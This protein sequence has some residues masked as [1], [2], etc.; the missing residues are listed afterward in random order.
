MHICSLLE[1]NISIGTLYY[2]F[3]HVCICT[4]AYWYY[5]HTATAIARSHVIP[6]CYSLF[7]TTLTQPVGVIDFRH[8]VMKKFQADSKAWQDTSSTVP[9]DL[10]QKNL[11]W[12]YRVCAEGDGKV[13]VLN[14]RYMVLHCLD[15]AS[16][17]WAET[18]QVDTSYIYRA[19]GAAGTYSNRRLYVSGGTTPAGK[20]HSTMVSLAV[21]QG[22]NS[23]VA[24]QQQPD[25]LYRRSSHGMAGV[26]GRILVCGGGGDTGQLANSE[27]FDLGTGTWSRLAD[28]PVA[29]SDLG[30]I[31]TA[32]AV[33]VLG[34]ITRY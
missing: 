2:A 21:G 10:L 15:V 3:I 1:N 14:T 16:R 30:L 5:T 7:Q 18:R 31:S 11:T 33:F 26:G 13:Y 28:M 6:L 17:Q 32:T 24:A 8:G 23:P 20:S 9:P 25:M 19:Q 27:V 4:S 22:G 12:N 34:G 29:K